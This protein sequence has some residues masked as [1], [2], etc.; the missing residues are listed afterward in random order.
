MKTFLLDCTAR[1]KSGFS[2]SEIYSIDPDGK[3]LMNVY[4]DMVTDGGGWTVIRRRVDGTT[5]FYL[6]WT[7]YKRGFGSL[8][9]NFWLGNDN[10]HRLTTSG[11]TVLRVDLE[12]WDGK[13]AYSVYGKFVVDD[14]NNKYRLS[15]ADYDQSST[16]GH[17]LERNTN[18]FFCTKD[19]NNFR[20]DFE[21]P[22]LFLGGGWWY[23]ADTDNN[24]NGRYFNRK[25]VKLDGI[26]WGSWA[27]V[28]RSLKRSEMKL[29]PSSFV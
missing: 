14:E 20:D 4:C 21:N 1:K 12:A 28:L 17:S 18:R 29:R 11:N 25:V 7:D 9:G 15:A 27:G 6:N 3:G 2:S 22:A 8:T 13:T 23:N 19:R 10:I 5:D 24:L 26:Y 16:A